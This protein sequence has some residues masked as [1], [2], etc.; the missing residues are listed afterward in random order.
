MRSRFRSTYLKGLVEHGL[1]SHL[2]FKYP[3]SLNLN[4]L[5]RGT[6][7]LID[8]KLI[9]ENPAL[10]RENLKR[11]GDPENL[12]LLEEFIEYDKAWRR[13]QTELN[14]AR[15]RRNEIS[16]EIARLKK[17]GLD[18]SNLMAEAARISREI[19]RLERVVREYG[20]KARR[21]LMRIPNLL[22]E[23]VPYGLDESD[24]VEIR[25]W[26]SPPKFDFKPKNHLEIAL[27]LGLIDEER[28]NKVAG[29]GF[30]YLKDELVLLDM[31]IQRFAIDFLRRR[32][33]TLIEP[34]FMLRRKP[35][36]GVTDLADFETVMY[37]IE[38][39]DLYLIATS[40]HPIAAMFMDET[41]D[42][43]DL[44]I[45]IVGVS[46]NFRK[47]VGTHGKYTKGL[48]RMHQFNKVEQ[49]IFC[50]PEQSWEL[51]EELQRNCEEMYQM[52]GLHYRVVNVCTGD[53]GTVAAKKYDTEVWMVDGKFREIGSNSNCTDYQA[54]RLRIRFR[55]GPGRPPKGFV[56]TLNSTALATS[57]T[58]MAILEHYQQ[59]DG[60]VI[61]PE[62]L[63]P[64]MNGI[65]RLERKE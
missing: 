25:R 65:E 23:S 44:P 27:D 24:N 1:T 30:Y 62:V 17:A 10:V 54:R 53:I 7:N 50:L 20:E 32:G 15:R 58:M 8:V 21:T 28:A 19:E 12:R 16:R 36:E 60:S 45:K 11:R 39:E 6:V 48:F 57:R 14:E 51:H 31:A 49:F 43:S 2:Q 37:K 22:H 63:R 9:R 52:L 47:E 26:G 33:Y 41:L 18:A 64:Y 56:H 38:G 29:S 55:E 46:T 5:A 4:G 61:I 42:M 3:L 40:E 59:K 13:V 34:P 35:Y